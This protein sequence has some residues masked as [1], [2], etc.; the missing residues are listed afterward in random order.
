MHTSIP[1]TIKG[2]V[3]T[4][5]LDMWN[6]H[7]CRGKTLSLINQAYW[8]WVILAGLGS[9]NNLHPAF[10]LSYYLWD[11]FAF[12]GKG[13]TC[14]SVLKVPAKHHQCGTIIHNWNCWEFQRSGTSGKVPYQDFLWTWG[15]EL[16]QPK[17]ERVEIGIVLDLL[18]SHYKKCWQRQVYLTIKVWWKTQEIQTCCLVYYYYFSFPKK[19]KN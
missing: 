1:M 4:R 11:R 9:Q 18:P 7:K 14:R 17:N 8:N 6:I 2:S 19:K 16:V 10:I 5:D 15:M 12:G 3:W 13:P